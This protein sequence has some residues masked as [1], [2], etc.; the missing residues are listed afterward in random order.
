MNWNKIININI[1]IKNFKFLFILEFPPFY[2]QHSLFFSGW[3]GSRYFKRWYRE[4]WTS[5]KKRLLILKG[6][7]HEGEH[8]RYISSL[9]YCL[10]SALTGGWRTDVEM[11]INK[12]RPCSI[13]ADNESKK[14]NKYDRYKQEIQL[15]DGKSISFKYADRT[16]ILLIKGGFRMKKICKQEYNRNSN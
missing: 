5:P 7:H 12:N 6:W 11:I 8:R 16:F 9:R 1:K 2:Y 10:S 4:R 3:S 13:L 15:R 14:R